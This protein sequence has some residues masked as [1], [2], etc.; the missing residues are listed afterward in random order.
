VPAGRWLLSQVDAPT[1]FAL[2]AMH[3]PNRVEGTKDLFQAG[4]VKLLQAWGH[5]PGLLLGDTN[6]GLPRIDEE[7]PAFGP[8]EARW[9]GALD[10][11]VWADTFRRLHGDTRAYTWYSPNGRNGFRI[12]HAFANPDFSTRIGT[13][14]YD[15]GGR[16][17][18]RRGPS[19]HAAIVLDLLG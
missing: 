4:V 12:D 5:G 18:S 19:D 10:G 16:P 11:L 13:M 6:S 14:R 2:G 15:W 1:P 8:R 9:I 17:G 7:S 3:V